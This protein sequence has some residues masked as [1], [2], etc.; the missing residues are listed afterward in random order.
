MLAVHCPE[1]FPEP[2]RAWC[3]LA[4]PLAQAVGALLSSVLQE[5]LPLRVTAATSTIL[6]SCPCSLGHEQCYM[7]SV[8]HVSWQDYNSSWQLCFCWWRTAVGSCRLTLRA[9]CS[10]AS[11]DTYTWQHRWW[12]G[13]NALVACLKSL[14]SGQWLYLL[15]VHMLLTDN[16]PTIIACLE[17]AQDVSALNLGKF[18]KKFADCLQ[19]VRHSTMKS[20]S[21]VAM[22]IP[23]SLFYLS[24]TLWHD[25]GS[26]GMPDKSQQ[27]VRRTPSHCQIRGPRAET[28]RIPLQIY[29]GSQHHF[30]RAT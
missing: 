16:C 21:A 11:W 24:K 6:H 29:F 14:Q 23:C 28:R 22:L 25:G 4:Q 20:V 2:C 8:L 10:L 12:E 17:K 13:A 9:A 5:I 26:A 7:A 1:S 30:C 15:F 18:Q 19:R 3:C 27:C